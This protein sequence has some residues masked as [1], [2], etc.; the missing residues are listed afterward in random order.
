MM[1]WEAT[2]NFPEEEPHKEPAKIEKKPVE[3]TEKPKHEEE[4]VG[5]TLNMGNQ[6]KSRSKNLVGREKMTSTL[7]ME[8]SE[9]QQLVYIMNLKNG[10]QKDG[11]K[12]YDEEG[13]NDKKPA[14]ENRL[15]EEPTLNNLNHVYELYKESGSDN[16]NIE[17]SLKGE[18]KKNSKEEDYTNMDEK[19]EG[20]RANL[21]NKKKPRYH[22]DIPRKKGEN[23]EALVT[24]EMALSNLGENIFIGDSAATSHMTSNKLGVYN[25]A[26][27]NGSVMI[28]NGQSISCTHKGKFNVI[29]KHKD[30]S[31]ARETWDV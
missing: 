26:P 20:K 18:N 9:Q 4:H 25:L 17:D 12:L 10:L 14:A 24:K 22:H 23:E 6:L 11:R 13:P 19:K 27:I 7:D 21:L 31:M 5:P 30:E 29:C 1:C 8:E 28:G 2:N 16:D 15:I 3:K